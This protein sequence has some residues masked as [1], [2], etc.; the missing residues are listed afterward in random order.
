MKKDAI[1]KKVKIKDMYLKKMWEAMA[2]FDRFG[3][4]EDQKAYVK[5]FVEKY[6]PA[7]PKQTTRPKIE[8]KTDVRVEASVAIDIP[9][10]TNY[11]NLEALKTVCNK[12][13]GC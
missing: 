13:I 9:A 2:N 1:N 11:P 10:T 5:A 6:P 3:S 12:H 4:T 7:K 8:M